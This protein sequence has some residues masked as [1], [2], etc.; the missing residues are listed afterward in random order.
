MVKNSW[1]NFQRI[2]KDA[3]FLIILFTIL[4]GAILAY[5]GLWNSYFEQDEWHSFGNYNFL[6]SLK[7]M[8]F[9]GN[10]LISDFPFH[11]APLSL[12]FKMSLYRLFVL[13]AASYFMVSVFIHF[14]VSVSV[15]LLIFMLTKKKFPAFLGSI[16]FAVNSSH[17]QAVTWIGTFEGVEFSVLFG[18]MSL[19]SYLLYIEKKR[20]KFLLLT[21]S[22]LLI[23]LLF[24][25]TALTFLLTLGLIIL[26]SQKVRLKIIG[27]VSIVLVLTLY[28][29]FR[30]AYLLFNVRVAQVSGIQSGDDRV[31]ILGYNFLTSIFKI[32]PQI[33][34]P[35]EVLVYISNMTTS[36]FNIYQYLARGPWTI[37][38][39]FRYDLLT[40]PLGFLFV[41]LIWRVSRKIEVKQ[42]LF[43]GVGII[44]FTI[45]PLLVLNRYLTYV[46][47]R[48]LYPATVGLSL[49][50]GSLVIWI[51]STKKMV[52]KILGLLAL[53]VALSFHIFSL[54]KTVD[55][56]VEI[57]QIRK[58]IISQIVNSYPQLQQ[59]TIF[60]TNSDSSFYG[61]SEDER[62]MPFQSGFGQLLLII[63]NPTEYFTVDFF[64]NEFLWNLTD[65][66]YKEFAGRGFG[67]FRDFNLMSMTIRQNYISS[68]SVIAFSYDGEK[69]M[70]TDTTLQIRGRLVSF[71]AEKEVMPKVG[72]NIETSSNNHD[73]FL[74]LDN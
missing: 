73:S 36:P 23:S 42:L 70:F 2:Q 22:L 6:L 59:K 41:A 29:L 34:F 3:P 64:K 7:G 51:V 15:Y 28:S 63:Y 72:W 30:F 17:Y 60:Y 69:G 53:S 49:I 45:L 66:G 37:E 48:Y 20:F 61:S 52:I 43:W 50:V 26:F 58:S 4:G 12:I 16:F 32:F 25:E 33:F 13:N 65:Q 19:V 1:K 47:S 5:L 24:K 56:L 54:R 71:L 67:Y 62:I 14:L 57:G 21:F 9:L 10:M 55:K 8:E 40:I 18:S 27:A 74:M 44:S 31:L 11:F 35:N 68:D 38:N 46:D 39:G